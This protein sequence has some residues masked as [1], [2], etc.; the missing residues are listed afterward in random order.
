MLSQ[1]S[2]SVKYHLKRVISETKLTF[3]EYSWFY[4][5]SRRVL[6]SHPLVAV[7]SHG[8]GIDVLTPGHFLIGRSLMSLPDL[9]CFYQPVSL[10][11]RWY[12]CQNIV[13]QFWQ[14]WSKDYL[15]TLRRHHK[16]HEPT[17][18]LS[19]RDIVTIHDDKL[20]IACNWPLGRIIST[21]CGRDG[22][23]CVVKLQTQ[24]GTYTRPV[25]KVA[26]LMPAED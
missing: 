22:L 17:R 1:F 16:W 25:H 10:L 15:V 8:K 4:H 19:V 11:K 2:E 21:H 6:N 13:R 20:F 18:N 5:R 14:R 3:E 7:P 12:L 23:V 24:Y 26:L 9:S